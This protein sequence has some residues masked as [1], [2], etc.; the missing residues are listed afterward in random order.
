[1]LGDVLAYIGPIYAGSDDAIRDAVEW[2]EKRSS[3]RRPK[4]VVILETVGGFIEVVQRIA[5]TFRHHYQHVEFVVP[6]HAMSAG[7]VLVMSGDAIWMDYYAVLGPIDPQIERELPDGSKRFVPALGYLH[8]YEEL[9]AKAAAGTLT[10]AEMAYLINRFD[11]AELHQFEQARD[12][13]KALL[14]EWLAKYKFKDWLETET[15][16]TPVTA[17]MREKRA[18]EIAE[19]LNDTKLWHTHSRGISMAV[20]RRDLN[21]KVDDFGAKPGLNARIREYYKALSDYFAVIGVDG[22]SASGLHVPG[23]HRLLLVR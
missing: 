18:E 8:K 6:N 4:L 20:L 7:T 12:L 3:K 21:L 16:K 9:I 13:S 2:R 11:P 22:A 15:T 1:M 23:L 17:A 10:S 14:K 5:D 19:M